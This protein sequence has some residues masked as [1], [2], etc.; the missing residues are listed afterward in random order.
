MFDY[1]LFFLN[2]NR[3]KKLI[4]LFLHSICN[5]IASVLSALLVTVSCKRPWRECADVS[6]VLSRSAFIFLGLLC[7]FFLYLLFCGFRATFAVT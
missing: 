7:F 3:K 6:V 1:D 5:L 2:S 4:A